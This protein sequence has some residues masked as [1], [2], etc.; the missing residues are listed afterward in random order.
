LCMVNDM[1]REEGLGK[2]SFYK[3][4]TSHEA[5]KPPVENVSTEISRGTLSSQ[6]VSRWIN[7]CFSLSYIFNFG[8]GRCLCGRYGYT[9]LCCVGVL[10]GSGCVVGCRGALILSEPHLCKILCVVRCS[11]EG[12]RSRFVRGI[13]SCL[14]EAVFLGGWCFPCRRWLLCL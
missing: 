7:L 9:A 2:N 8:W 1:E 10:P 12:R 6:P 11:P 4:S 13:W 3:K 14:R 5:L